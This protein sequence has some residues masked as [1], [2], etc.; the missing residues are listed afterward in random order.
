MRYLKGSRQHSACYF[1]YLLCVD[2]PNSFM[3]PIQWRLLLPCLQLN[4]SQAQFPFSWSCANGRLQFAKSHRRFENS[5]Q[6]VLV[7]PKPCLIL[8]RSPRLGSLL[9]PHHFLLLHPLLHH[10][11]RFLQILG[12]HP[13]LHR[14]HHLLILRLIQLPSDVSIFLSGWILPKCFFSSN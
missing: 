11:R 9:P 4:L 13:Y 3:F 7:R 10:L 14:P 5:C 6:K 8:N 2:L 12:P 1:F